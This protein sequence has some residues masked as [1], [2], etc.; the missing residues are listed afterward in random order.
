MKA[1]R[2]NQSKID[3]EMRHVTHAPEVDDLS[4]QIVDMMDD[5]K[6][7]HTHDRLY[8]QGQEKL[9]NQTLRD[10]Q[11]KK[12]IEKHFKRGETLGARGEE[13][14]PNAEYHRGKPTQEAL[15][16]MHQELLRKQELKRQ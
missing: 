10:Y 3:N 8:L 2:G 12:A 11:E 13:F 14:D 9:R 1:I 6:D 16:E 7:Q 15:Y 5:R 4:N